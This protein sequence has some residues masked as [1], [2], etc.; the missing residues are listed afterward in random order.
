LVGT[1]A[2]AR[3]SITAAALFIGR[4]RAPDGRS[5]EGYRTTR[6]RVDVPFGPSGAKS[7]PATL[8]L[9]F[10]FDENAPPSWRR[11]SASARVLSP[12]TPGC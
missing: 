1:Q 7:L 11:A 6:E 10:L 2:L 12:S 9:T 5:F 4:H 8:R 3:R